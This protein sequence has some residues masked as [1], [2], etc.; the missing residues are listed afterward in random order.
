M[1]RKP[2]PAAPAEKAKPRQFFDDLAE[3]LTRREIH[4]VAHMFL[5]AMDEGIELSSRSMEDLD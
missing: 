4:A 5:R 1:F 3:Q 2:K